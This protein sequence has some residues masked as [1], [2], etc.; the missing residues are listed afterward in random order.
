MTVLGWPH[1]AQED[2]STLA[3]RP[4]DTDLNEQVKNSGAKNGTNQ[5]MRLA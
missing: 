4:A 1:N 5:V 2:G 3:S